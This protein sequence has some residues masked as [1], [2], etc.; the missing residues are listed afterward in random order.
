ML[1]RSPLQAFARLHTLAA[2]GDVEDDALGRPRD[3]DRP[4]GGWRDL[5]RLL[6]APTDAPALVAAAVVHAE[7]AHGGAVRARTTASSP[8]PPNGS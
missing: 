4:R 7:L 5:A 6:L 8:A 1:A 3:A 2:K